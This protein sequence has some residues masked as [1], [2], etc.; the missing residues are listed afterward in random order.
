[1]TAMEEGFFHEEPYQNFVNS[2]RPQATAKIY[3]YALLRFM[4]QYDIKS[5]VE[6]V[7]MD[8]KLIEKYVINFLINSE[9]SGESRKTSFSARKATSG[10]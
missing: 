6:F 2:I 10:A 8:L 3:R 7:Q 1:M 5:T 4:K 9:L